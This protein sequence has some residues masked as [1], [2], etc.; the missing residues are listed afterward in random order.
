MTQGKPRLRLALVASS[1]GVIVALGASPASAVLKHR[2]TFNQANVNDSVGTAHGT[3]VDAGTPTA[4]Y[5]AGQIDLSGN[6]GEADS[7]LTADAYVDLPNGIIMQ[8]ARSGSSGALSLEFWFT[9]ST[10]R[11][12]QMLGSFAGPLSGG[13]GENVLNRDN[14]SY[15]SVTPNSGLSQQGPAVMNSTPGPRAE[16]IILEQGGPMRPALSG[17]IEHHVVAIFDKSNTSGGANPGG[18]MS[19]YID[20]AAVLPGGPFV[21]GNA[22]IGQSFDLNNL[23]DEDN[24]LGRSQWNDPLFDGLFNEFRIYDHVLSAVEVAANFAAGPTVPEPGFSAPVMVLTAAGLNRL[25]R[26]RPR[27]T[28][29]AS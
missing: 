3:V 16:L 6:R 10:T 5:A 12:W 21:V 2:Y 14:V 4:F 25:R 18:T 19:L 17:G 15:I 28:R 26:R 1:A 8:A 23:N 27:T 13:G 29:L 11:T 9:V 7:I 24:W 20:G 22:Q